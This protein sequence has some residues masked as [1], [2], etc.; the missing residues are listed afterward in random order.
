MRWPRPSARWGWGRARGHRQE[1]GPWAQGAE[2]AG[3]GRTRWPLGGAD[4]R[5]AL[6]G[7]SW[8]PAG[9]EYVA[10]LP[11]DAAAQLREI[12][13]RM[14]RALA[15]SDTATRGRGDRPTRRRANDV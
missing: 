8:V 6:Y 11:D 9:V 2:A 7:M 15:S 5:D 14:S 12:I 10:E 3:P 4:A 1:F 13:E